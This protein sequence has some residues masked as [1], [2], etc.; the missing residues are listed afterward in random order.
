MNAR[1]LFSGLCL[2]VL[3]LAAA[4]PAVGLANRVFLSARSGNDANS[5]DDTSGTIPPS[6]ESEAL[7]GP[8]EWL[9]GM[10]SRRRE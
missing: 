4:S 2:S 6:R 1:R 9:C 8:S 7:G 3:C 5:C 10:K